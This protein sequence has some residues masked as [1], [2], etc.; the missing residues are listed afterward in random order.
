M[1]W[2]C[3]AEAQLDAVVRHAL[4]RIRSPTPASMQQ[5]DGALLEHA[6]PHALLDVLSRRAS[7]TTESIPAGAADAQDETR[8]ARADDANLRAHGVSDRAGRYCSSG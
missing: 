3:A 8:R 1:R 6:G 7:R 5:I 2:P 4:A